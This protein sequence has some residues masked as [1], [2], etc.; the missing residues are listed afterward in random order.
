M[1]VYKYKDPDKSHDIVLKKT[2]YKDDSVIIYFSGDTEFSKEA[3]SSIECFDKDGKK[4]SESKYSFK[5]KDGQVIIK[6]SNPEKISGVYLYPDE[7]HDMYFMIRYLDSDDYA[8]LTNYFVYDLGWSPSGDEDKYLFES[9][10]KEREDNAAEAARID[11]EAMEMLVGHWVCENGN[12]IDITED[13]ECKVYIAED[14]Y[15]YEDYFYRIYYYFEDSLNAYE[16]TCST[17][18]TTAPRWFYM[19]SDKIYL[20]DDKDMENKY[21]RED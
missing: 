10:K 15:E 20:Y 2:V 4:I 19:S 11:S 5:F 14:D 21:V 8:I 17:G 6:T 9:E 12:T 3:K 1:T 7:Y 16:F 13:H 18:D